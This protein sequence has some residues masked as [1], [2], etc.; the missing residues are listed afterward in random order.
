M[1]PE[2]KLYSIN[3]MLLRINWAPPYLSSGH[4]ITAY[5]INV[6]EQETTGGLRA[7][8]V[9]N[10]SPNM[11]EMQY[12]FRDLYPNSGIDIPSCTVL[13]FRV[14]AISDLGEST[15]GT[16]MGSYPI[17]ML[18][19]MGFT[20]QQLIIVQSLSSILSFLAPDRFNDSSL[21]STV[22]FK[23]DGSVIVALEFCVGYM[24]R[25]I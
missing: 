14:T 25:S 9:Y 2:P 5:R 24:Y 18:S 15:E 17:G 1:S 22:T 12:P 10:L 8:A 6:T 3:S 16:T 19:Y 4:S 21:T 11:T 13:E 23:M 7:N 20:Y